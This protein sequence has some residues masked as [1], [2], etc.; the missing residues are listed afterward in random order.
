MDGRQIDAIARALAH[1]R[2]RRD[3]LRS[4]GAGLAG[5]ALFSGRA[6]SAAPDRCAVY[7]ADQP[8]PRKA[9]C[10]QACQHCAGDVSRVCQ[11][12]T[13]FVCVDTQ[14]DPQNCGAC[15]VV[16]PS[17]TTCEGG[18]CACDRG[19]ETAGNCQVGGVSCGQAGFGCVVVETTSEA[20]FC[21]DVQIG[22]F[23]TCA[24]D[25]DCLDFFGPDSGAVCQSMQTWDC[26]CGEPRPNWCQRPC[27][28]PLECPPGQTD[29]GGTCVDVQS[30]PV[31]CGGCGNYCPTG[32]CAQGACACPDGLTDCGGSCVDLQADPNNCGACFVGCEEGADCA[33]GQCR[34]IALTVVSS[35]GDPWRIDATGETG[36]A[37]LTYGH[38]GCLAVDANGICTDGDSAWLSAVSAMPGAHWIW[39]TQLV[40]DDEALNGTQTVTFATSFTVPDGALDP[41]AT[42]SV[43]ADDFYDLYV[44]GAFVG[45]GYLHYGTGAFPIV[46][47]PG[48][49]TVEVAAYSTALAGGDPYTSPAGVIYRIDVRYAN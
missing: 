7:C 12:P 10:K 19:C 3:L 28:V 43:L 38:L 25:Q 18:T 26:G 13:A 16:C 4:A 8:G 17:G 11:T 23:P 2:S 45:S 41:T 14:T 39:K 35:A 49:N 37:V 5:T 21:A 6:A 24:T 15:G 31:N 30:D 44:N 42:V 48:V 9:S 27:P 1:G 34:G 33:G 36:S 20:C 40:S 29:C 32:R 46:P 22:G 47:V